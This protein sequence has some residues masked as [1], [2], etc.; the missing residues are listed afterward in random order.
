MFVGRVNSTSFN[1]VKNRIVKFLGFGKNDVQ[2]QKEAAPYGTD[3]NPIKNM[4]A[5]YAQTANGSE[6]VVIGYINKN[7]LADVGEHRTYSTDSDGNLKASIW[8]KKDGAIEI[9]AT[10]DTT[11]PVKIN[12]GTYKAVLG[13]KNQTVLN[14][15]A[16]VLTTM[17][18]W[19]LTVTPPLPDQTTAIAQIISDI[20]EILSQN[21]TLD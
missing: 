9:K 20:G 17:N 4:V 18:T 6:S 15:I 10:G 21:V 3:S 7:Q 12:S 14:N 2:S 13:D 19:G 16:T 1:D 8:L 5:I 11:Q